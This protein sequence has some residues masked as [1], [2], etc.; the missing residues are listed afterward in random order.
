MEQ[1]SGLIARIL[2]MGG[3][4]VYEEGYRISGYI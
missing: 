4:I 1:Y 3:E 2:W